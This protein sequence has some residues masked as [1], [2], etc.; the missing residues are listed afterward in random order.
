MKVGEEFGEQCCENL[1]ADK[2]LKGAHGQQCSGFGAGNWTEIH[3]NGSEIEALIFN[4]TKKSVESERCSGRW[5]H[6]IS[7]DVSGIIGGISRER[8]HIYIAEGAHK[9]DTINCPW[10]L[11]S[12]Q[13]Q[14][15]KS[16]K[17]AVAELKS[18]VKERRRRKRHEIIGSAG[19]ILKLLMTG[20]QR[21]SI[22]CF[23]SRLVVLGTWSQWG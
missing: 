8:A 5:N 18:A 7:W 9:A 12:T 19:W 2:K 23:M 15:T 4:V 17:A 11:G 20:W 1:F 14:F 22:N 6:N 3:W 16:S 21:E 13:Q 10:T